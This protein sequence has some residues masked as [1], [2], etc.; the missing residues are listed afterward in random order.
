MPISGI[1]SN[2][3]LSYNLKRTSWLNMWHPNILVNKYISATIS[4]HLVYDDDI[5]IGIDTNY[6]AD[7]DTFGPKTQFKDFLALD[8]I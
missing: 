3:K 8:F 2:N 4:N 5:Y 1:N 6:D 7:K